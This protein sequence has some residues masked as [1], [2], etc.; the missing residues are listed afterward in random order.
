MD[1]ITAVTVPPAR[2]GS[3]RPMLERTL[4]AAPRWLTRLGF[5]FVTRLPASSRLR[6]RALRNGMARSFAALNRG[7]WWYTPI[8]YESDCEI[9]VAAEFRTLGLADRYRGHGGGQELTEAWR[10]ELP[11]V[12]W[13]PEQL[14][15]LG[16]RWVPRARV[17]G[18]GRSSGVRTDRTWGALYQLSSRG[19]IAR[20]EIYCTWE[21]ALAA[22]ELSGS[23]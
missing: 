17:S 23:G 22:A 15:D 12:R 14:I 21:E 4:A 1:D 2:E 9:V 20:Q 6:R 10:E 16:E 8:V 7:D 19:R 13:D 5:R 18:S 3:T 11:D